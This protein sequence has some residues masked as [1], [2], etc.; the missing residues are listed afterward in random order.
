MKYYI[1]QMN[2]S[3]LEEADFFLT[4]DNKQNYFP[5]LTN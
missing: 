4:K 2:T 5:T 3:N 1:S